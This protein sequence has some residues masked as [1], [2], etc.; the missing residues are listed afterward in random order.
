MAK[1]RKFVENGTNREL[2]IDVENISS[3]YLANGKSGV[4]KITYKTKVEGAEFNY[5]S[6]P[7]KPDSDWFDHDAFLKLFN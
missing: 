3:A 7:T 6:C 4:Y 2:I 1:F 5:V